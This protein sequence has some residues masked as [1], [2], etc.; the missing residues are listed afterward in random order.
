M[1]AG[2]LMDDEKFL[3]K[4]VVMVVVNKKNHCEIEVSSSLLL[5]LLEE[6]RSE[7]KYT[8]KEIRLM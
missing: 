5:L 2:Y 7:L 8:V 6:L 1:V 3:S 4:V